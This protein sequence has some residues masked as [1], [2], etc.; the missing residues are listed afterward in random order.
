[1]A[2]GAGSGIRRVSGGQ[3]EEISMRKISS[4]EFALAAALFVVSGVTALADGF[5]QKPDAPAQTA[6]VQQVHA[7]VAQERDERE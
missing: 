1:M 7:Q 3:N 6:M 5:V 4:P 2:A